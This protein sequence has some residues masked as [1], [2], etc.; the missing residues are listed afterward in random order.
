MKRTVMLL[1]TCL[2]LALR[3]V[4][5]A[6]VKTAPDDL[7]VTAEIV[8]YEFVAAMSSK[9]KPI[10]AGKPVLS[11]SARMAIRNN[12]S[13]QREIVVMRCSW[14]WAW[15][16]KGAYS[17]CGPSGCDGNSP[18]PIIIPAGQ[19]VEFYDKLCAQSPT[20]YASDS[21]KTFQLGFIDIIDKDYKAFIFNQQ[22]SREPAIYWSNVLQDDA[23]PI[24]TEEVKRKVNRR[25]YGLLGK[26]E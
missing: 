3:T 2:L 11:L 13:H 15:A 8:G 17:I 22:L 16:S 5:Q 10:Q 18:E 19:T 21:V 12:T 23:R 26:E 7:V 14:H 6:P 20:G 4:A 25:Q 1:L 9:G 24:A